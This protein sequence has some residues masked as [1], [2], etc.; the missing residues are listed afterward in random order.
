[1]K[2]G[3]VLLSEQCVE[4]CNIVEKYSMAEY[5]IREKILEIV[6]LYDRHAYIIDRYSH[7]DDSLEAHYTGSYCGCSDYNDY[8]FPIKWLDREKEELRKLVEADKE[9]MRKAYEEQKKKER[10]QFQQ[11][12]ER[13]E[14]AEYE[15]LKAKYEKV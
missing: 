11:D 6:K 13:K 12:V 4:Y 5:K 1:M 14:K 8:V 7:W 10:E 15:R 2:H 3:E 9:R